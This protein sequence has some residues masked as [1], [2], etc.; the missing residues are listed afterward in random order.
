[1]RI[2]VHGRYKS[3]RFTTTNWSAKGNPMRLD[4]EF[5]QKDILTLQNFV[6][7]N[8]SKVFVKQRIE[9][10]IHHSI[11]PIMRDSI[12]LTMAMC[13]LTTQQRSSPTSPISRFLFLNPFP[14]SLKACLQVKDVN[15]YVQKEISA[16]G[17]IRFGPKIALQMQ[18]NLKRLNMGGWNEIER[19]CLA[20]QTQQKEASLPAHYLLERESARY[21]QIFSGFGPKQSRNFWQ[22]MGLT[23]YEF[24]LDS[25]VLKWLK[26]MEFPIPL[27]SMGLGEEEYYCFVSDIL[28]EWCSQAEILPCV[29]DAAIFASADAEEWPDDAPVW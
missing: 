19:R 7:N 15:V 3:I 26:K 14:L 10:N 1:M 12:W 21:I 8:Q 13:L 6:H 2:S 24:V 18:E 23:Q 22:S 25:R 5:E 28:R 20:L 27:S 29:L 9:R 11:P 17:G 4:F 16:F